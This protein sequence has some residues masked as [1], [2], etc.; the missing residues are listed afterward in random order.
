MFYRLTP[1]CGSARCTRAYAWE[2]RRI[3]GLRPC[4]VK[5]IPD[6]PRQR[7]AGGGPVSPV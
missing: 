7:P 5:P 3:F 1:F 2:R 4:F 6:R